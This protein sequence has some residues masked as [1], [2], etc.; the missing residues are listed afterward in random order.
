MKLLF[1]EN[2]S[3][4]LCRQLADVFP[5]STQVRLVGLDRADDRT[6]WDFAKI[7][8]YT[9]VTLDADLAEMAILF[10]PPPRVVWMRCGNQRSH[11]IEQIL[12]KHA[13]AIVALEESSDACVEL[14]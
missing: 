11:V 4:K 3:F 2:L 8:D 12:R 14:Y 10:G 6:V 5:G 7:N 1:D 9:I 13:E